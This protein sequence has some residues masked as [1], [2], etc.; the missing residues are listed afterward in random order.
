MREFYKYILFLRDRAW[1]GNIFTFFS[2]AIA[3]APQ[4]SR[5]RAFTKAKFHHENARKFPYFLAF[6][7]I[8]IMKNTA[9]ILKY[10]ALG[11]FGAIALLIIWSF[12]EPR[13][14]NTENEVAKWAK[15]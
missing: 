8:K 5:D 12:I 14:L 4:Q 10:I 7:T 15:R 13:L 11:I 2:N 9:Q 3:D 6:N 1:S